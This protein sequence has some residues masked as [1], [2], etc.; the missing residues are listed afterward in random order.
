MEEGGAEAIRERSKNIEDP[1]NLQLP[2]RHSGNKIL[3]DVLN[4]DEID[5]M[6]DQY[7]TLMD[8]DDDEQA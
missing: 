4:D 7:L 3:K 8:L 5:S 1:V 6:I 2:S